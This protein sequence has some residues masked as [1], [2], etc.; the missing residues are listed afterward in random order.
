MSDEIMSSAPAVDGVIAGAGASHFVIRA[1]SYY[2]KREPNS[3]VQQHKPVRRKYD[4]EF[5]QQALM[6]VRNRQN[7]IA[8][9]AAVAVLSGYN[10][11]TIV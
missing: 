10:Q 11:A 3:S 9:V 8:F 7:E 6:M 5:K 2:E 1:P 4:E